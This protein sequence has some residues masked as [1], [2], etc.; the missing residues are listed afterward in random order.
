MRAPC[1]LFGDFL[2]LKLTTL[3]VIVTIRVQYFGYLRYNTPYS[4]T[5]PFTILKCFLQYYL[6]LKYYNT[7]TYN[8]IYDTI[9]NYKEMLTLTMLT[10]IYLL[11][12]TI[13]ILLLTHTHKKQTNKQNKKSHY[14]LSHLH[15]FTIF[16]Y[17]NRSNNH[18][19]DVIRERVRLM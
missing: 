1:D 19:K 13:N 14:F 3:N 15:L 2:P 11:K 7:Y 8:A 17:C 12:T 10:F 16:I 6:Y 9:S 4:T 18:R 5:M